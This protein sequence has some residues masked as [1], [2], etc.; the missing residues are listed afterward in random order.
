MDGDRRVPPGTVGEVWLR[1]PNV[2][3]E[4]WGDRGKIKGHQYKVVDLLRYPSVATDKVLTKDGW[5][6]TG[7]LG[8]LDEEGFLYIRDRSKYQGTIIVT[9]LKRPLVKDVII[10]GGENIVSYIG[11]HCMMQFS[12]NFVDRTRCRLKMHSMLTLA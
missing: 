8:L 5:L 12:L 9:A 3:K 11:P 2:M 1:G 7:D 4:Y 10:R 6:K